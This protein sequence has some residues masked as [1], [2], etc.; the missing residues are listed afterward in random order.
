MSLSVLGMVAGDRVVLRAEAPVLLVSLEAAVAQVAMGRAATTLD[1]SCCLVVPA[2][3]RIALSTMSP[4]SRVA[5]LAI[6]EPLLGAFVR[7]HRKLGVERTRFEGWLTHP[8]TLPRTLWVHEI[9][10][11]YVF[12]RAALGEHTSA[13][14]RF[15]EVEMVKEVYF[16]FRDAED[17][18]ERLAAVRRY[19]AIV[20]RA[21][22]HIE[23]HLFD[24][25]AT[26][27]LA[28]EVGTSGS[29]LLRAFRREVGCA[30]GAYWRDRRLDEALALLR[31]GRHSVAEVARRVGYDEPTAFGL[32]FRKRFDAPP[33]S[34]LPR[35]Q[36]R[37]APT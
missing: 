25:A 31:T 2:G 26:G 34:F 23:A 32:A 19:S 10:H 22:A 18:R 17:G 36:V 12:E 27:A 9:V 16:L 33:S 8:A 29:T 30:P 3:A 11:R 4:A 28:S 15:L 21:L 35:R 20:E 7:A 1:R 37:A 24:L 5:L 13:A 14:A 6:H